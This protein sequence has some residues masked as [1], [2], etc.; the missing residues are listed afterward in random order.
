MNSSEAWLRRAPFDRKSS[1]FD[2]A[3]VI[4]EVLEADAPEA[5]KKSRRA[6]EV[7]AGAL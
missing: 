3:D 4:G 7:F 2:V 6:R 5:I 1:R